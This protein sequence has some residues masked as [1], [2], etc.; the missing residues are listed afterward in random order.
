MTTLTYSYFC[1]DMYETSVC[2]GKICVKKERIVAAV[3]YTEYAGD[4][5][6]NL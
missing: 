4:N 6:G 2:Y 3:G 5:L 1:G